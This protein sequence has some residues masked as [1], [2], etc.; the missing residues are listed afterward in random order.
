MSN[1]IISLAIAVMSLHFFTVTYRLNGINRSLYNIPI[2]IF[3]SSIPLLQDT[4]SFEP[5][6]DK[7]KLEEKLTYYLDNSI[8]RYCHSYSVE[9]YYY[10]QED[11]DYALLRLSGNVTVKNFTF[12][13]TCSRYEEV[14]TENG[15]DLEDPHARAYCYHADAARNVGDV[16]TIE[17]CKM[18][19]DHF[20]C[21]G[22][23]L[24]LESIV[25]I[26][27]CELVSDVNSTTEAMSDFSEYGTLYGHLAAGQTDAPNQNLEVLRCLIKNVYYDCGVSMKN[28]SGVIDASGFTNISSTLMFVQ[29]VVRTSNQ[30]NAFK[31]FTVEGNPQVNAISDMSYGNNINNMNY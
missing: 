29:N 1:I 21:I 23:G 26:V 17:N 28:G 24:R 9:F 19:N 14:A 13:Q 2:S 10:Y 5:Y 27:D 6:Y 8:S 16:I 11:V 25:R 15:W 4:E 22:F 31:N 7:D 3:E 30:A 20:S 18:Y 12:R